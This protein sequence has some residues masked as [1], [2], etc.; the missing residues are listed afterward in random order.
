MRADTYPP[1][2]WTACAGSVPRQSMLSLEKK[3]Q[4]IYNPL[5]EIKV[6]GAE[7]QRLG[8]QVSPWVIRFATTCW[9]GFGEVFF[10]LPRYFLVYSEIS[11]R[12]K[13]LNIQ[14]VPGFRKKCPRCSHFPS[15]CA[16]PTLSKTAVK[17]SSNRP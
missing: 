7:G 3:S 11:G 10:F 17:V 5:L 1:P 14:E 16:L 15:F 13:G 2:L 6:K 4:S 8:V 9:Q 12:S